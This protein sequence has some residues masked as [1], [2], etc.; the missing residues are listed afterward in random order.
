[1]CG[2]KPNVKGSEFLSFET[3]FGLIGLL[4]VPLIILL[5]V[6]KQKR[7]KVTV[8]SLALWSKVIDDMQVNT[9]WQKLRKNLLMFLQIVAAILI[10]LVLAGFS[11]KLNTGEALSVI[12]VI[13][14]SL[15]MASTDI[16]PTRL[17]AAKQDAIEYVENLPGNSRVTVVTIGGEPDVLIYASTSKNEVR[18]SI[19][20]ISQSSGYVDAEKAG[21]LVLFLK[22]Q[23]KDARIVLFSDTFFSFGN[24]KVKFSEYKKQNDNIAVT[25][26]T[27]TKTGNGITAMSII[28]N[29]GEKSAEIT[30]SL[31]GDDEFIDSKWVTI[32]GNQ[33][34][35]IWWNKI[36]DNVRTLRVSV[37]T[38]D[39]LPDDNNGYEVVVTEKDVKILLVTN[40][41]IFLEKA[42]SLIEGVEVARTSPDETVYEGYDLYVFD[43]F[44]PGKFPKDGNMVI[45]SPTPNSLFSV[46]DWMD[47][48]LVSP[49]DHPVFRYLDKLSFAVGRT[50]IIGK[51]EWAEVIMEYSGN[52]I[53]MEG[54]LD[55]KRILIFGFNLF[56]TDLPLRA[57]FPILISNI[58]NE[59]APLR[60]TVVDRI[61]AGDAVRFRL[62]PDTVKAYVHTP[63]GRRLAIEPAVL[64]EPFTDT[65]KPGIYTLEQVSSNGSVST[66]FDVNLPDEW[67]MEKASY[68]RSDAAVEYKATDIAF[69][70]QAV[71]FSLPVIAFVILILLFEWWYYANRNY[72]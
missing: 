41:N 22:D 48:P 49:S 34:K 62:K 3:P 12:I 52:P 23:E 32:P 4:S 31:Y 68:D 15:S 1:M 66:F 57:E 56:E 26:L 59:Y 16:K 8:S 13:D 7:E 33:T 51:P 25:G 64:S 30:V 27:Y 70:K 55:N 69:Q 60:S 58:V 53:I 24:E 28:R 35:T 20:S 5:Y 61:F 50:R 19:A 72:V 43:G 40:G 9:P 42:L 37:E 38:E 11:L 29:Q 21:E 10:V 17:A 45:F 2:Q 39:I 6:L 63:D 65:G 54:V 18:K 47:N 44:I 71:K 14:N 67:V 36:P 46:G